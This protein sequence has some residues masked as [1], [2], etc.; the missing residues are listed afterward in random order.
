MPLAL[1]GISSNAAVDA[2]EA[3]AGNSEGIQI[4]LLIPVA[5][6]K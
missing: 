4:R 3:A 6:I 1:A 2:T 5:P